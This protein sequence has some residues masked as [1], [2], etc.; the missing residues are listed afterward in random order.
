MNKI[1][2]HLVS[3]TIVVIIILVSFK[4]EFSCEGCADKNK[5]PIANAGRDTT[6]A[7]PKDSI[8]LDGS[9]SSDPDGRKSEWRWTKISGS[10]SFTIT[11]SSV[12]RTVVKKFSTG[13]YYLMIRVFSVGNK[14]GLWQYD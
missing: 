5:P 13:S 3:I 4:K 12:V 6:I 2:F 7:L 8:S 11:N 9:N 10:A 1:F 14:G